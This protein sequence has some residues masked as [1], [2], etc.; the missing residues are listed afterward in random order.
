M[1]L[2]PVLLAFLIVLAGCSSF[3]YTG[4]GPSAT[5]MGTVGTTTS[6]S[7]TQS[8]TAAPGNRSGI[9]R[10]NGYTSD[11]TLSINPN[12][13]L[14]KTERKAVVSRSMAR[15]ESV[16]QLEFKRSVSVEVHSRKEFKNRGRKQ[17]VSSEFRRFDN[18]KF[19]AMFLIGEKKD[20]LAVQ[21]KSRGQSVLG[22][23][24]PK[25]NSIVI[26]S[27][28]KTPTLDGESTLAHEL[29]HALQDQHFNLSSYNRNT[30]DKYN[31][32]NG[33]IEGGASF[34]QQKYMSRCGNQ[35]TCL[36]SSDDG[37][38]GQP[39]ND[40]GVYLLNYFPYADGPE[41]IEHHK[42]RGG[43]DRISRLF[44]NPPASTEQ[45]ITPS[46]YGTDAPTNVV[47]TDRTRN[48]WTRVR[49]K[50]SG[51]GATHPDYATLGQSALTAMFA[52]AAF[53]EY[54]RSVVIPRRALINSGSD[55]LDYDHPITKGWD[56]DRLHVYEKNGKT[57]YV[58]KITWDSPKDA[59]Q[60]TVAY[61][62]LL[63]HW[64]GTKVGTNTWVIKNSPYA[65]AFS[66][67]VSGDTVTIVNAPTPGALDDVRTRTR[68]NS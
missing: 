46:K 54:N 55:S 21:S 20:S 9:G 51:R 39:P 7:E 47:L 62:Q 65:D 66:V 14:N 64:G 18:A 22:Y 44:S 24:S 42:Q 58:W 32:V 1:R 34:V 19:E 2:R 10:E 26:V 38:G 15:I 63:R 8:T 49:L 36:P 43:W 40:W 48:G 25:S 33:V 11:A 35:W 37:S 67:R 6:P 28:S 17:K 13:G 16:R 31:A 68:T 5:E 4:N 60:F 41:F 52:Q 23:Y 59:K 3:P 61:R 30:R 56:G 53:D 29:T 50:S 45:V 57:S 12:N 27:N